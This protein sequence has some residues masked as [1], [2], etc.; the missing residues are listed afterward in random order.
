VGSSIQ[1]D[2]DMLRAQ[3]PSI[4]GRFSYRNIDIST[5]KE[6]CKR[7]NPEL[8]ARFEQVVIPQK[9]HRVMPDLEDTI[10]EFNSYIESFL[11]I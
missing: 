4:L 9:K 1:F 11:W 5:L 6:L 3:Y 2:R 10:N 7:L 8:Y